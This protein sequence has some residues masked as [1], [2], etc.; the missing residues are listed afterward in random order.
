MKAD[1]DKLNELLKSAHMPERSPGYWEAFPKRISTQLENRSRLETAPT[2]IWWAVGFAGMC[3]LAV[4]GLGLWLKAHRPTQ[5]D[6]ARLYTEI[7]QM[8]PN[9][10]RAIVV[11]GDGVR[12][13]LADRANVPPSAPLR[14]DVCHD[15]R[16]QTYIT[17]SG[18][19]IRVG[20]EPCDVLAD[21]RGHVLVVGGNIA[22]TSAEPARNA[23]GYHIAAEPL[24]AS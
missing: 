11:D 19:Q 22:W 14:V 20:D 17:F 24:G 18:Q 7:T 6:Y 1:D 12:L 8:F 9:Q 10:V 16:C 13:D 3:C 4:L 21:G 2:R 15:R 23:D 5:P